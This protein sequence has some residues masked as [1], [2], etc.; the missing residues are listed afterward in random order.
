M[1]VVNGPCCRGCLK[2]CQLQAH[3]PHAM[4]GQD[5]TTLLRNR[6]LKFMLLN[7]YFDPSLQK[8]FLPNIRGCTEHQLKLSSILR[9]AQVK[10]KALAV[11]WLDLANGYGSVHHSLIEFSLKH[12]HAPPQF[13]SILQ[14]LYSGLNGVVT[15]KSWETP[16]V[17]LQK[18]VYQG[19]PLTV[20][21]FNTVMNTLVDTISLR[22]DLGY[23]FSG[24]QRRVNILQY[25]D[26]TCLLADSPAVKVVGNGSKDP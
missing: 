5:L 8:A 21:I 7:K 12:Y 11:C 18:G 13:L 9:E 23:Q 22:I 24:S 16:L 3:C 14:S 19:D 6:W 17:S 25:A 4:C 26:D 1:E 20:A 2:P 10:H 15:T